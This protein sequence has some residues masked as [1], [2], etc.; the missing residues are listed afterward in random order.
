MRPMTSTAFW[1]PPQMFQS[2]WR[3]LRSKL[4]I[5]PAALAA[6]MPS[7]ISSPVVSDS[8]AK[9]PPLWNQRAPPAKILLQSKSPGLSNAPASLERL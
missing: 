5:A 3:K 8:A 6:F 1:S 4:V 9:M 2:F 7:A